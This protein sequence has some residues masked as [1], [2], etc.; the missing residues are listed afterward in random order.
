MMMMVVVGD[1]T[2]RQRISTTTDARLL[3]WGASGKR[4]GAGARLRGTLAPDL[5][6]RGGTAV[7]SQCR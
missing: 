4:A 7:G 3:W 1:A 2:Y 5:Y 6:P